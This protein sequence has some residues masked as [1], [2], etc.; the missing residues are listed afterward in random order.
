M[1]S[2][3]SR[4]SNASGEAK[5]GTEQVVFAKR[6]EQRLRPVRTRAGTK[7]EPDP[8]LRSQRGVVEAPGGVGAVH[9]RQTW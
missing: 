8:C 1:Q 2:A 3:M 4:G 7:L 5:P 9:A 6:N